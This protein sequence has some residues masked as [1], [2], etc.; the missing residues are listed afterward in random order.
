MHA[1]AP[2]SE[3]VFVS[4]NVCLCKQEVRHANI[5]LCVFTAV[6]CVCVCVCLWA[7]LK[8]V[9]GRV[10]RKVDEE[11]DVGCLDHSILRGFTSGWTGPASKKRGY[12]LGHVSLQTLSVFGSS[13]LRQKS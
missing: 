5:R 8:T 2:L 3:C 7:P 1:D 4:V 9:G 10:C 12:I 6:L 11:G 13:L